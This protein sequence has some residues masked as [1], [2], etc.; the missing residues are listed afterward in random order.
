MTHDEKHKTKVQGSRSKVQGPQSAILD[1]PSSVS[2]PQSLIPNPC[3][4]ADAR[5]KIRDGDL[6][7]FRPR[8]WIWRV[9]GVAGRSCYTHAAMAGWWKVG[10]TRRL[11]CVEMTAG[12]GRAQ[13]LSNL[14]ARWPGA[15]DVYRANAARRKFSRERALLRMIEITGREYGWWNLARAALVHLPIFRFLVRPAT[16]DREA[17]AWPPFCSQAAAEAYRA[18]GVDPV[19]N[20]A[21]RL[22]EPGDL[23]RSPFFQYRFTLVASGEW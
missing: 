20:L 15:I 16:D 14:A 2:N 1:S 6:L 10:P 11:M 5:C 22:T 21:D 18:G 19:P 3:L 17:T 4:Y 7:L 8:G 9:V 12:G 13:L 23:A